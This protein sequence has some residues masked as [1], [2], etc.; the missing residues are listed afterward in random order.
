VR[1][2]LEV[3]V[4]Y[5]EDDEFD[6]G[7]RQLLNFGHCF[8]HAIESATAFAVP[9]GQAVVL[10]M[11]VAGMVARSRGLLSVETERYLLEGMLVPSLAPGLTLAGMDD[12]AVIDAMGRDKKRVGAGLAVVMAADGL[13]MLKAVDVTEDEARA[14]LR[15]FA[16]EY[17]LGR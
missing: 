4:A 5:I 15:R 12:S 14:A 17:P 2:S 11:I 7:R 8:G 1:T 16:E 10:G 3:K 9:H 13:E 6:T